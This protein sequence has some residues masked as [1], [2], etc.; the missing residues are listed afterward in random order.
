MFSG[1]VGLSIVR[2]DL[3]RFEIGVFL[4]KFSTVVSVEDLPRFDSALSDVAEYR[5]EIIFS[6]V[7]FE[8]DED[9]LPL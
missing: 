5:L 2:G 3:L 9:P 8:L 6:D 7:L 1:G 4:L